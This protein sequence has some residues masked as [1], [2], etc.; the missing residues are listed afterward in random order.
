MLKKL[1]AA[2]SLARLPIGLIVAYH[3]FW[4]H[5]STAFAIF[6]VSTIA[7][8]AARYV[9]SR[10]S[11]NDFVTAGWILRAEIGVN[12]ISMLSF[13]FGA[14]CIWGTWVRVLVPLFTVG[15]FIIPAY[16]FF[17]KM[18]TGIRLLLDI[19]RFGHILLLVG[20]LPMTLQDFASMGLVCFVGIP[21]LVYDL[22]RPKQLEAEAKPATRP[23]ANN[24]EVWRNDADSTFRPPPGSYTVCAEDLVQAKR[25]FTLVI[26]H[27]RSHDAEGFMPSVR[28]EGAEM[29]AGTFCPGTDGAAMKLAQQQGLE[30]FQVTVG[31]PLQKSLWRDDR[32]VQTEEPG[33]VKSIVVCA[34]DLVQEQGIFRLVICHVIAFPG[35]GFMPSVRTKNGHV[36]RN[37]DIEIGIHPEN[38]ANAKTKGE[39][40]LAEE[41][42]IREIHP[43]DYQSSTS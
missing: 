21:I 16:I 31:A 7:F 18:D 6:A 3:L 15:V 43:E 39:A 4:G 33:S 32:E 23:V 30:L 20:A 40:M 36:Q 28:M 19:V 42:Y 8:A 1:L 10:T 22:S 35:F 12:V 34:E 25:G 38:Y 27:V 41:V 17:K 14:I 26:C 11:G 9:L 37:G 29:R 2:L 5:F 13:V 24:P